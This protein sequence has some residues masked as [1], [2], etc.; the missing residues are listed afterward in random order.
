MKIKTILPA[1]LVLVVSICAVSPALADG[2]A[3][4][5]TVQAGQTAEF[6]FELRNESAADHLYDLSVNGLPESMAVSFA[7]NGP[8]VESVSI[9]AQ[10]HVQI[11]LRVDVPADTSVGNYTGQISAVR[12]D[13]RTVD[14]PLSLA[15]ENAYALRIVSQSLNLTAF[16]GQEFTFDVTALN[17]GAAPVA[18]ASLVVDAPPKWIVQVDPASLSKLE[19]GAE[20]LFH[21]RMLV[22]A[23]QAAQDQNL[24]LV[25]SSDQVTSPE[26]PLTVRVQKSPTFFYAA[27]GLMI[28]AVAGVLLYFR[29]KGRR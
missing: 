29:S 23:S 24:T 19:T 25:L 11:V 28:L 26:S 16:S 3:L 27:G 17:S 1:L 2:I 18:N 5:Q 22:P 13:G 7:Q 20:A 6:T 9:A 14:L 4:A 8:L 15:V 10:D 21:V 12:D